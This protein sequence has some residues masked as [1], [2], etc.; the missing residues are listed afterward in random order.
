MK[1]SRRWFRIVVGVALLSIAIMFFRWFEH[2]QVYHPT[3]TMDVSPGRMGLPFEDVRFQ[4]SDGTE[5]HGWFFPATNSSSRKQQVFLICHGNG[6]NISHRLDL[7][8]ALLRTGANVFTFDYRGYGNSGGRPGEDGTYRDAQSAYHWLRG[9]GFA[10]PDIIAYGESLG[11]AIATELALREEPGALVLQSTFTSI[12]EIGAELF[13]WLPV[14]WISTIRYDT[15]SK[16]PQ[17]RIP[18]LVMH[19]REDGLVRFRHSE[20]NMAAAN[21]PKFF[22]ELRG[23]HNAPVWELPEFERAIEDFL[24]RVGR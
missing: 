20:E 3:R 22:C 19:S 1:K 12:P 10:G 16:L 5:L 15:R 13:P 23:P 2:S 21:E 18:V 9:R 17:V 14:R 8:K 24:V 11:G 4:A 7:Y 6:G